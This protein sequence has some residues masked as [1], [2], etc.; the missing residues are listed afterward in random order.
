[1][2]GVI[3]LVVLALLWLAIT[4][5][6]LLLYLL[7]VGPGLETFRDAAFRVIRSGATYEEMH[8]SDIALGV[9]GMFLV[10]GIGPVIVLIQSGLME[11][12]LR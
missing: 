11:W 4:F 10:V 2:S 12:A 7:V 8:E 5:A 1:M 9:T 6:M 3:G